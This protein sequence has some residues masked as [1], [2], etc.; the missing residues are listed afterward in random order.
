MSKKI[1]KEVEIEPGQMLDD[2]G[3]IITDEFLSIFDKFPKIQVDKYLKRK[4]GGLFYNDIYK[5]NIEYYNSPSIMD[6]QMS[7]LLGQCSTLIIHEIFI[8]IDNYIDFTKIINKLAVG[9]KF[10]NILITLDRNDKLNQTLIDDGFEIFKKEYKN[11]R[12]GNK[13]NY[14]MKYLN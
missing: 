7:T 5:L 13:I 2:D 8:S 14:Y 11:Q 10:S 9:L 1:I 6:F 3:D 12:T 4:I